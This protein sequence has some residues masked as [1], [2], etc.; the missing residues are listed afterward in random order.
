MM[1]IAM[2]QE[3]THTTRAEAI[4]FWASPEDSL[5]V[6]SL[7]GEYAGMVEFIDGHFVVLD[8]TGQQLGSYSNLREAKEAVADRAKTPGL[9]GAMQ[10]TLH[11]IGQA[12]TA[13]LPKAAPQ[14]HRS[15]ATGQ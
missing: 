2:L 4:L 1:G 5:W 12:L 9:I 13:S 6:A 14:Y 10:E 11:H 15:A 7:N 8:P 3:A